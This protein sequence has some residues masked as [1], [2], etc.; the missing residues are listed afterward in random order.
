MNQTYQSITSWLKKVRI[1]L[2][3][4]LDHNWRR[5]TGVPTLSRSMITPQLFLGGQYYQ[6]G[7]ATLKKRGVTAIVNM[8]MS[9]RAVPNL[10]QI[11]Y[12][13]LPTKDRHPPTLGQLAR[14]VS[15]ISEE[16]NKGGKV[17]IHCAY[18]ETRGPT[19]TIAYL[20]STGLTVFDALQQVQKVRRFAQPTTIQL[21]QLD[22]YYTLIQQNKS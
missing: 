10:G 2:E 17:Y 16:I 8:R 7:L 11:R 9:D 21:E 19:M 13:H 12:L 14:G 3:R 18:G 22:R 15:F 20:I 6:N 1:E 5:L 4:T